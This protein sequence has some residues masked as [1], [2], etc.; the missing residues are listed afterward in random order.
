MAK[1][2]DELDELIAT[3]NQSLNAGAP[4]GAPKVDLIRRASDVTSP[5]KLR[6]P[7]GIV[8]LDLALN[9]GWPAGGL[10]Q[11]AGPE[12]AGKN[13]LC[14]Q[15][16]AMLQKTYGKDT[17]IGWC[18]TE[19]PLDKGYGQQFGVVV[20]M[21]N[22]DIELENLAR[23]RDG[24]KPMDKKERQ[25]A[26]QS[27]GEFVVVD[28]GS[29]EKRLQAVVEMVRSNL[30]QIIIVDS[31]GALLTEVQ[32][33]T[34]LEDE[35]QQSS[36]ARLVTRFQNK[37][38]G[39]F[40]SPA[41]DDVNWTTVIAINQVRA[42]RSMA[43]FKKEWKVAGAHALR[44]GKLVDVWLSKSSRIPLDK[45]KVAEG[46]MVNWEIAKGKAGCHD[47][48]L[49]SVEYYYDTGYGIADNLIATAKQLGLLVQQGKYWTLADGNGEVV[50]DK[51]PKME[52]L[53]KKAIIEPDW[54][55]RL[56]ELIINAEGIS[57]LYKR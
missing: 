5:F 51:L 17:R 25:Q 49:G 19:Y 48:P 53:L 36:E 43:K 15:T 44:H 55:D 35:P 11:I 29:T 45:K 10:C 16:L 32:D 24:R 33:D 28:R 6:R 34:D 7:T 27:L 56:Y 46:R 18:W 2:K 54:A 26:K 50:E 8:G 37:L 20:P 38:H 14:W 31:L 57:C 13:A 41:R 42:N 12:S 4:R 40:S 30:F 39:A 3:L 52:E 47:G 9:G 1:T 21:S 23:E 22:E